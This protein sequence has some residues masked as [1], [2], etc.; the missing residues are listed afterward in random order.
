[1]VKRLMMLALSVFA[2]GYLSICGLLFAKQRLLIFPAP[3]E[4]A[5]LA[6]KSIF[7]DVPGGTY[8]VWRDA[9]P[10]TPV[11]VHFHG[12][13][14]QVA[15]RTDLAELFAAQGVS[16]AAIEYPGYAGADGE[17]TEA[18]LFA[19]ASKGLEH[20][21]GPLGVDRS[22]LVLSG[23]S[24]GSGVAV[25]MAQAGW[26]TKLLLLTPYTTLPDVGA[27]AFPWLPVRLLMRDRFDSV[28][29]AKGVA[30]PVTIIHGTDD[31]VIPFRLGQ[32][33]STAFAHATFV[34][35]PGGHHNDLWDRPEV[36]AT[37]LKFVK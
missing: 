7:V 4:R 1:V 11:V 18:S 30:M 13:G 36:V 27:A 25:E 16:F 8:L 32:A 15:Y 12:N 9:G 2:I 5:G 20:L 26:G 23:Q 34:E 3:K 37:V 14:E 33:L 22:R 24:L 35:V 28:A 17:P 6:G 21:T 31:E 29:R 19:A 10:N